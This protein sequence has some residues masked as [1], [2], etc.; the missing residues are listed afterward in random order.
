[1]NLSSTLICLLGNPSARVTWWKG[2]LLIDDNYENTEKKTVV[3]T[4]QLDTID[5]K[6][7]MKELT[8]KASNNNLTQALTQTIHIDLNC[9]YTNLVFSF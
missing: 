9:T 3:N 1:M 2:A 5:R 4:L 6:D 7:L 8:C